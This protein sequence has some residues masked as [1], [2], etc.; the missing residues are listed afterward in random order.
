MGTG[1]YFATRCTMVIIFFSKNDSWK[2]LN[3]EFIYGFFSFIF[4]K[5]VNYLDETVSVG[6]AKDDEMCNFYLMYW[7]EGNNVMSQKS[8]F[9]LGPPIYSWDGWILGGGLNNIP[10]DEA[11][12]L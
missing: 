7:V 2:F 12:T 6:P 10:D 5:K 9:S 4:F 1:D 3:F 8:C 11:S